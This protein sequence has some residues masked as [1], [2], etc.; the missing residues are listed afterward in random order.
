MEHIAANAA[1]RVFRIIVTINEV[2]RVCQDIRVQIRMPVTRW[3]HT[4]QTAIQH[5]HVHT[6]ATA[7][8]QLPGRRPVDQVIMPLPGV[9]RFRHRRT[10]LLAG[11]HV[12]R[13][14]RQHTGRRPQLPDPVQCIVGHWPGL[15]TANPVAG[16]GHQPFTRSQATSLFSGRC[17]HGSS[18]SVIVGQGNNGFA[19][20]KAIAG[21]VKRHPFGAKSD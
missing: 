15:C 18:D 13:R 16:H 21:P 10:G 19:F 7:G 8:R 5:R 4:Q 11:N 6:S 17:R 3:Q 12:V 2:L 1:A 14:S 9:Q 20:N